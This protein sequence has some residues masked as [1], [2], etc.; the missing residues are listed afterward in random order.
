M[1]VV[2]SVRW[3]YETGHVVVM[4]RYGGRMYNSN[5]P[6]MPQMCR[7]QPRTDCVRDLNSCGAHEKPPTAIMKGVKTHTHNDNIHW[8]QHKSENGPQLDLP[9]IHIT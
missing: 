8:G 1:L 6:R 9:L 4:W 2:G 3:V 5:Q 7:F